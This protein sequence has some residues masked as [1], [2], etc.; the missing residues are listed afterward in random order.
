VRSSAV[1]DDARP[2]SQQIMAADTTTHRGFNLT[3]SLH[4]KESAN[5]TGFWRLGDCR[6]GGRA[7]GEYPEFLSTG[8]LRASLCPLW[9]S[10]FAP[11][12]VKS[13]FRNS[14]R[15]TLTC[16]LTEIEISDPAP[17]LFS[18]RIS[19]RKEVRAGAEKI[20]LHFRE[21]A[22]KGEN[23]GDSAG[24]SERVAPKCGRGL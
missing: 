22:K 14:E 7:I 18:S 2:I 5:C 8:W 24:L 11:F 19:T 16:L 10:I 1:C 4:E 6:S 23:S 15:T 12:A 9:F 13:F 3:H 17:F 21:C 20:D